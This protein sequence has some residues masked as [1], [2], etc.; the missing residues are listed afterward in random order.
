MRVQ[1]MPLRP[2]ALG[3]VLPPI[4]SWPQSV[5]RCVAT[6]AASTWLGSKPLSTLATAASNA[7]AAI[8]S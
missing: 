5:P 8:C 4:P 1:G 7:P 6:N 2:I 3:I